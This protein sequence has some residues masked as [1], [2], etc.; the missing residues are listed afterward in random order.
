MTIAEA[1]EKEDLPYKEGTDRLILG[2]GAA[3]F[4]DDIGK[5]KE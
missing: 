2:N 4:V 3:V 5:W 1:R